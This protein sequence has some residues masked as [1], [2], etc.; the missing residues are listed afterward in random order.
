MKK[1][2]G[3]ALVALPLLALP[4]SA[5][6]CQP[7]KVTVG[8]N[9]NFHVGPQYPNWSQ[10]GPWYLYWPMEAHF[11][12]PAP[13]GY[14]YWPSAQG[15]PGMSIGGPA[16]PYGAPPSLPAPAPVGTPPAAAP[17]PAPAP[18]QPTPVPNTL[19][20]ASY[21]PA[22]YPVPSYWYDR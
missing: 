17:I 13:T 14:P 5:N 2:L 15:L 21:Q 22:A 7:Y 4:A 9:V 12:A 11:V 6:W 1:L 19:K 18:L 20:P 8:G 16:V 3:L 10:L